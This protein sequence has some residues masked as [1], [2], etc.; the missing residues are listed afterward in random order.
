MHGFV[1]G[2]GGCRLYLWV[3]GFSGE[4]KFGGLQGLDVGL[5]GAMR[6]TLSNKSN[7]LKGADTWALQTTKL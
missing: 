1:M 5:V 6:E 7:T 3:F 4:G 2:V